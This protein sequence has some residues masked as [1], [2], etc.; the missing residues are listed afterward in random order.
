MSEDRKPAGKL[1]VTVLAAI[2]LIGP[3][4]L[5][6]FF[7]AT[8]AVK[9]AFGVSDAIAGL[10]MSVPLFAMAAFT[11]VYGSLSDRYGRRPVLLAG[12]LIFVAG[13]ALAA[14]APT[15]WVLIAGRL[16]QAV[17]GACGMTLARAIARDVFGTDRLVK[18]IAYLL[19]AYALGPMVAPPIGGFLVD[20]SGWRSLVVFAGI[21][22]LT[23]AILAWFVI[24]ETNES[25]RTATSARSIASDY[26]RL[27][28][29]AR[30]T[31]FVLQSGLCSGAFFTMAIASA[32]VMKEYL[33]RP[34]SEYG[35]WFMLFPTGYWMGNFV[36]SRLSGRV[37][38][39]TMVLAGAIV[40]ILT[41]AGQAVL[42]LND[43]VV[44]LTIFI[45]GM[46]VTFAQGIARP[47]AQAGALGVAR[48]LAG[49]AAGIGAFMQMFAAGAFTQ[50]YGFLADGT[51]VPMVIAVAISAAL[52][53]VAGIVPFAMARRSGPTRS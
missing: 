43:I 31:A 28:S 37:A 22:G 45:P 17:G 46:L 20:F 18:I 29:D 32:F 19:M 44:P 24:R 21:V 36:S 25:R 16:L 27:F 14:A 30:F 34:A 23:L 3:L 51:P 4:A 50:L 9:A 53:F 49:T 42:V 12:I 35:L 48:D 52:S 47:N 41:A 10:T 6:L 15:I 33:H 11:L 39:E 13:S 38:I 5:H 7:P 8:P 1:F 2:T 26:R 40:L